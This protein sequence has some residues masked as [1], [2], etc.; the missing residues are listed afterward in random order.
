[1]IKWDNKLSVN[2][3]EIDEQHKNFINILNK[4]SNAV[5]KKNIAEDLE[6]FLNELIL[7]ANFHFSTEEKYFDKFNYE[8]SKEH[9]AEHQ[10]IK[11]KIKEF[12]SKKESKNADIY[13]VY[14]D[15]L[16]FLADWLVNHL[17]N[18]DMKYIKC[19]N[20]NGLV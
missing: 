18:M 8:G 10:Q 15:L 1:M 12:V 19:F 13:I 16:D 20:D 14:F 11:N 2:V 17:K 7:Y 5:N 9:K 4:I 6:K 3:E